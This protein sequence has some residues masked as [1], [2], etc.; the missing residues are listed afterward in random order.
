MAGS[1]SIFG[2]LGIDSCQDADQPFDEVCRKHSLDP[3]TVLEVLKAGNLSGSEAPTP[4]SIELMSLCELC[5][6]LQSS[7]HG[8]LQTE[9][10]RLDLLLSEIESEKGHRH[11]VR[12][13]RERF[14]AF[15]DK[16]ALHMRE[17]GEVLFPLIRQLDDPNV[18]RTGV[19]D[20]LRGPVA[21]MKDEHDEVDEELAVLER[22]A[23]A[24]L[25]LF[26]QFRDGLQHLGHVLHGQIYQENQILFRR[27]LARVEGR[28]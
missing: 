15:R 5:D 3:R 21:R 24:S 6:Y 12:T 23:G 26:D 17:E 22:M 28:M 9:L 16:L 7:H 8:A 25:Q 19:M 1:R 13:V 14:D 2:N 18:A 4:V 11:E 20:L 10:S 27:V